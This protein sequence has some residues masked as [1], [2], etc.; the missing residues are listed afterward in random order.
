MFD[1]R[2]GTNPLFEPLFEPDKIPSEFECVAPRQHGTVDEVW[3]SDG[4]DVKIVR[5]VQR[6][7]VFGN[8]N[9]S[10]ILGV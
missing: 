1:E 10:K 8:H 5:H 4:L 2:E 3:V 7:R 9:Q 6:V